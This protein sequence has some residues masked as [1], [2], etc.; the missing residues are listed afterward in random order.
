[1]M[2]ENELFSF[3]RTGSAVLIAPGDRLVGFGPSYGLLEEDDIRPLHGGDEH[4][5]IQVFVAAFT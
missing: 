4:G 2:K 5:P 1:M 3:M